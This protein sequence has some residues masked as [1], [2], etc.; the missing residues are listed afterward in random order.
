MID[1]GAPCICISFIIAPGFYVEV[2]GC[3][4]GYSS[5]ISCFQKKDQFGVHKN[6]GRQCFK[7]KVHPEEFVFLYVFR[8]SKVSVCVLSVKRPALCK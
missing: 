3:V 4:G 2:K 6:L 1:Q 7:I 5:D 8:E